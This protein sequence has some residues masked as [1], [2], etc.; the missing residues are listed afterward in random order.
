MSFDFRKARHLTNIDVCLYILQ[1]EKQD[2]L[3]KTNR[4]RQII[5]KTLIFLRTSYFFLEMRNSRIH[6]FA[7]SQHQVVAKMLILLKA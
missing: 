7:L 6:V 1:F 3:L 2:A 5:P 4:R